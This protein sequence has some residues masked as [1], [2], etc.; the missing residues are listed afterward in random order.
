MATLDG[1][2]RTF[3]TDDLL[4]CDGDGPVAVAGV[5]GGLDTEIR[6]ETQDVLIECAYFDPRSIRR[7]SRRL[8]LHTDSSHRFERGVDP[9]AVP[10]VLASA[11]SLIA[12]LGGGAAATTAIDRVAT[13]YEPKTIR[14]VPPEPPSCSARRCRKRRAF[15]S[16]NRLDAASSSRATTRSPRKRRAGGRTSDARSTLIEEVARVRGY[17]E[18]PTAVPRVHPS[19][20]GTASLLKFV[21]RA[22]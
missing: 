20:S 22:A 15:A 4:I 3:T 19:E 21:D 17:E 2:E 12:E 10:R 14:F 1:V 5:M 11:A 16:S 6:D 9:E 13:P 7:T 18:I 8:G